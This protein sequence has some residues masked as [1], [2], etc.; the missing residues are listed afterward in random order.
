MTGFKLPVGDG[1]QSSADNLGNDGR[2]KQDQSNC[3]LKQQ[4]RLYR[5]Q[6]EQLPVEQ[7]R[8][9]QNTRQMKIHSSNGVFR[10]TSMYTV[11]IMPNIFVVLLV[12]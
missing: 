1:V 8:A 6:S 9:G 4:L 5:S 2:G 3:C 11:A 12:Q 10:N 7:L